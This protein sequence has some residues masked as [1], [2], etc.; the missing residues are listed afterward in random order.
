MRR[1]GEGGDGLALT[2]LILGYL[3]VAFAV[4]VGGIVI[5]ILVG[6]IAIG[7]SSSTY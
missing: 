6:L 5:L 7:H 1:T 4:V 3:H 2:G